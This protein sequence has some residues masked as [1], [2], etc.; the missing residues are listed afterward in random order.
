MQNIQDSN[1]IFLRPQQF[2]GI[3]ELSMFIKH[4]TESLRLKKTTIQR[5]N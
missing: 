3:Y 5:E 4:H 2:N 1:A